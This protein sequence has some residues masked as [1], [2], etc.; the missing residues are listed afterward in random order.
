[1]KV[2]VI[3][4]ARRGSVEADVDALVDAV[5]RACA[6]GAGVIV[7]PAPAWFT[8][9]SVREARA[10][11]RILAACRDAHFLGVPS[12]HAE[13][14]APFGEDRRGATFERTPLGMTASLWGD[15]CLDPDN[16]R[17]L[18]AA[19][20][21][22]L[23][24]RP[25]SESELQA[26]AM[27]ERALALS[28]SVAGLVIVAEPHGAAVGEPGHGGS[29]IAALGE[30]LAEAVGD[31]DVLI[32][33]LEVVPVPA[34]EPRDPPPGLPPILAQRL[35]RHRGERVSVGYPADV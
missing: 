9:A 30:L 19:A 16:A 1:M 2:A 21:D 27:I 24:L 31:E 35:S 18:M 10:S 25:G 22:A 23:V 29:V 5:E 7:T 13:F 33:E 11:A 17:E 34:P 32:A 12:G 15:G 4:L 20:P 8:V 6:A 26:E 3:D 14:D 28:E